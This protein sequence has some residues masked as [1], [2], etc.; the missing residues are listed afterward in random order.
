M[1]TID[2]EHF[3]EAKTYHLR[4]TVFFIQETDLCTYMQIMC[5]YHVAIFTVMIISQHNIPYI[6]PH[7]K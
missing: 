3:N 4:H 5:S 7:F 6:H 1:Q 2:R